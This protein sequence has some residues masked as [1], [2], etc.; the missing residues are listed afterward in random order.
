MRNSGIE[1]QRLVL[2]YMVCLLHTLG[3]G[4]ILEASTAG[5]V[6]YAVFWFMELLAYYAVDAFAF[7]SG[8]TASNRPQKYNRIVEMWFQAFFYSFVITVILALFGLNHDM[9]AWG[10]VKTALPVITKTFWYFTA[11]FP[12]FFAMPL[13]NKYLFS[14]SE[15][16]AK[17]AL[18]ILTILFSAIGIAT[19]PF[20]TSSG[21]S[22]IWL[23]VLYCI[24]VLAKRV[25]LFENRKTLTLLLWWAL[26]ILFLWIFLLIT[27]NGILVDYASPFVV[28]C[29][30]LMTIVF[31]RLNPNPK[32]ITKLSPLA[33]G[34][35][36]CQMSPVVWKGFNNAFAGVASMSLPLGILCVVALALVIFV[37]GMLVEYIRVKLAS[38]LRISL[39]SEK[40]V[41]V[42][43]RALTT[44]F[45]LMK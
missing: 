23:M 28:F 22:A 9:S 34:I 19:D 1:L 11:Y 15:E 31:S 30:I 37:S 25:H 18:I 29:G 35:Y 43:N 21:Y 26:S 27:D 5:T 44:L 38:A 32:L 45:P 4:G 17:K 16:T 13:F 8:Y 14:I 41:T 10:F 3:H 39:L 2:M 36:L 42:A 24:G 33:F 7:I 12:L 40:I 20:Y 6:G